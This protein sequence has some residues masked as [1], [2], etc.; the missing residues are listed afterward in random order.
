MGRRQ[1]VAAMTCT[2]FSEMARI[3]AKN[4]EVLAPMLSRSHSTVC[5]YACGRMA[6]P[7]EIAERLRELCRQ[8]VKKLETSGQLEQPFAV[9]RAAK[10]AQAIAEGQAAASAA[11]SMGL[12]AHKALPHR[13]SRAKPRQY[14]AYR[15]T[16][17]KL[18]LLIQ[19]IKYYMAFIR[20]ERQSCADARRV[21]DL[22]MELADLCQLGKQAVEVIKAAPPYDFYITSMEWYVVSRA[23]RHLDVTHGVTQAR[24]L[25]Q[26]WRKYKDV[27]YIGNGKYRRAPPAGTRIN[28]PLAPTPV[29]VLDEESIESAIESLLGGDGEGE[30]STASRHHDGSTDQHDQAA[31]REDGHTQPGREPCDGL[32]AGRTIIAGGGHGQFKI[33]Q[34]DDETRDGRLAAVG[35]ADQRGTGVLGCP[36]CSAGP[37]DDCKPGCG[38]G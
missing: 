37:G 16:H 32:D 11:A 23:L 13:R 34:R 33:Q 17:E 8:Q 5:N 3:A 18:R 7:F 38:L 21:Q 36:V 10:Y 12:G 30:E 4:L 22:D 28:L 20:G 27:P 24:S 15:M 31:A 1:T 35:G 25:Y 9:I 19:A 29:G 6:V 26:H 2:E 14:P